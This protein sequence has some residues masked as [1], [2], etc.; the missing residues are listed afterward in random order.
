MATNP[1]D[2]SKTG[3]FVV[4]LLTWIAANVLAALSALPPE[5]QQQ[6]A[7]LGGIFFANMIGPLA[8]RIFNDLL[9]KKNSVE[10]AEPEVSDDV[11]RRI[12]HSIASEFDRL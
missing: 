6:L 12:D 3:G 5:N 1:N 9:N 7:A 8:E 4:V 11:Q 2:Q 10:D